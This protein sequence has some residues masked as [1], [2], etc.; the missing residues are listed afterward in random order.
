MSV[1][2]E[3]VVKAVDQAS[4]VLLDIKKAV[5]S[6]SQSVSGSFNTSGIQS[7]F[8]TIQGEVNNI[9]TTLN[10][11]VGTAIETLKQEG[12]ELKKVFADVS[13]AAK[14]I[15]DALKEIGEGG[16]DFFKDATLS[17]EEFEAALTKSM[18][19]A[20]KSGEAYDTLKGNL[21][22]LAET[23]GLEFG[24][25]STKVLDSFYY[26]LSAGVDPTQRGFDELCRSSLKLSSI[27][28]SDLS[29]SVSSV[30]TVTKTFGE[31]MENAGHTAEVLFRASQ[32]GNTT[33]PQ[34]VEAMKQG[35]GAAH[36]LGI[37]LED[38]AAIMVALSD[39][40]IRASAAGNALKN[41]F[42]NLADPTKKASNELKQLGVE[43]YDSEG[44]MRP[45]MTIIEDLKTKTNNLSEAERNHALNI[46]G[47]KRG[48]VAL[49]ALM[50][51]NIG[52]LRDWTRDLKTASKLEDAVAETK[53]TL[54]TQVDRLK[55]AWDQ[56]L[57]IIGDKLLPVL[58]PLVEKITEIASAVGEW[59]KH[60][61]ELT[62]Q[63]VI[64][65]A[66]GSAV[67]LAAGTIMVALGGAGLAI[68]GIIAAFGTLSAV[69]G[70]LSGVLLPVSLAIGG[71]ALAAVILY[72]VWDKNF[73]GIRDI[74]TTAWNGVKQ[75]ID[76]AKS[77]IKSSF[78]TIWGIVGGT[79]TK[80]YNDIKSQWDTFWGQIKPIWDQAVEDIKGIIG[81]A[82]SWINQELQRF[83]GEY[84]PQLEGLWIEIK[85]ILDGAWE[86]I[87]PFIP[88]I[89]KFM[90]DGISRDLV[91][92]VAAFQLWIL[93]VEGVLKGL[94]PIISTACFVITK[95]LKAVNDLRDNVKPVLDEIGFA[96][97][98]LEGVVKGVIKGITTTIDGFTGGTF[99]RLSRKVKELLDI[100]DRINELQGM[101]NQAQGVLNASQASQ[102]TTSG[103]TAGAGIA[104]PTSGSYSQAVAN[105][106]AN[107]SVSGAA[108]AATGGVSSGASA[109]GATIHIH[110]NIITS[111]SSM[112]ALE[113]DLS[114]YTVQRLAR[115]V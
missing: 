55:E 23:I 75:T 88:K 94:E 70:S 18:T 2:A 35:G 60:N 31:N 66:A 113:K 15:G 87:Q 86:F 51:E 1:T 108:A 3:L 90:K 16:L 8:S 76:T 52:K 99:S 71:L 98:I 73:L 21:G 7:A 48:Y 78:D 115:S 47:G 103:A 79:V 89:M 45:F 96:F 12:G 56:L 53:K 9:E 26:A 44:K 36:S 43:V 50:S 105:V 106:I 29:T 28:G 81:D 5:D 58:T 111:S 63:A 17:A 68:P 80:I 20:N 85:K 107:N 42:L 6:L 100:L 69:A 39:K 25:K 24:V 112:R 93:L 64:W 102:P 84:K 32:M 40:G 11:G 57:K 74:V 61:P 72:T 91:L 41:I 19:M 59:M 82:Y 109:R 13:E 37:P 54:A 14:T 49:S 110:G 33:I 95:I 10:T 46:L 4:S 83:W 30:A 34:L 27:Y 65:G 104:Y 22:E 62:K 38:T 97:S 114:R 67:A 101:V 92:I 77:I